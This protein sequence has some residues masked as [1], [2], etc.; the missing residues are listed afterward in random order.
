MSSDLIDQIRTHQTLPGVPSGAWRIDPAHSVIG[1][2]VRHLMSKVRGRFT[3]V[4]GEITIAE[5]RAASTVRA[6][7]PVASVNTGTAMRDDHLRSRD[8]FD[9][10]RHPTMIFVSTELHEADG[11]WAL[12]GRL[13]LCGTTCPVRI[14]LDY[15]GF[16]PDGLQGE[17]R[18]GFEGRTTIRRSDFGI[19]F[20]LVDNGKIV[21]SDKIEILLE[22][23]AVLS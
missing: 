22:I 20:G 18:I 16:D 3:E 14:E 2:A 13:T 17:P 21:I 1:F 7:I 23:E 8:F 6:E 12:D 11:G 5:D 19:D 9:A 10:E 4:D 15:L